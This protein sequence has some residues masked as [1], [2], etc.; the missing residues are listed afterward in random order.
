VGRGVN[1]SVT[2]YRRDRIGHTLLQQIRGGLVW[3]ARL[4]GRDLQNRRRRNSLG[5]R[6]SD[7]E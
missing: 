7:S 4:C 6:G 2:E 5:V 3:V 1:I